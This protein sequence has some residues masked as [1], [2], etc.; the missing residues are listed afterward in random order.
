MIT[1]YYDYRDEDDVMAVA[2]DISRVPVDKFGPI[3][4]AIVELGL[5][6]FPWFVRVM[7]WISHKW[8]N[9]T[10]KSI[11]DHMFTKPSNVDMHPVMQDFKD[12]LIHHILHGKDKT[13][14]KSFG[15][16]NEN[17][18]ITLQELLDS[19]G[20]LTEKKKIEENA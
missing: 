1:E 13:D 18:F 15:G 6:K 10:I 17:E 20:F 19:F 14:Q 12:S 5:M 11:Y 7:I 9:A 3:I 16:F 4:P 2:Q 8:F